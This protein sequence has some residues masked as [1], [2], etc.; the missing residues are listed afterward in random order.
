MEQLT[1]TNLL[2]LTI[3]LLI[4]AFSYIKKLKQE[5]KEFHLDVMAVLSGAIGI[6][7]GFA[8]V[9]MAKDMFEAGG[10]IL[11]AEAPLYTVNAFLCG[12]LPNMII[13]KAM[14]MVKK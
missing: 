10:A 14:K 4:N 9:I 13:E 8:G 12:L 2:L 11:E 3:G 6:L 5:G 1:F 7:S